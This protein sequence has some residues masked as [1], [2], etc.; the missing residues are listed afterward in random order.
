MEYLDKW[1]ILDDII[2]FLPQIQ[3]REP[4]VLMS[5]VGEYSGFNFVGDSAC[6]KITS[7]ERR[8]LQD[9]SFA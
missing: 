6:S 5:I 3:S 7:S 9:G 4:A 8:Y 1:L 2:P